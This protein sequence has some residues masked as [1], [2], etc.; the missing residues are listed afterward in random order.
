VIAKA[1]GR[2]GRILLTVVLIG[3][4]LLILIKG[5]ALGL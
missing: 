3:I 5:G 4:G 2:W 1:F